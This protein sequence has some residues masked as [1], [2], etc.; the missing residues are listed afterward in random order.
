[1]PKRGLPQRNDAAHDQI[2]RLQLRVARLEGDIEKLQ[3]LVEQFRSQ[4]Q[5]R[6]M[7]EGDLS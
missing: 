3:A 1:M 2:T 4:H 5:A 7:I 6:R